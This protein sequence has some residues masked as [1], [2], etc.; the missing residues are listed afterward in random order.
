MRADL[1]VFSYFWEGT[2]HMFTCAFHANIL[3]LLSN[4]VGPEGIAILFVKLK[5][6]FDGL[7]HFNAKLS[8]SSSKDCVFSQ[9]K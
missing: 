5:G 9:E 6:F 4:G 7:R 2:V 8:F 3:H 1:R